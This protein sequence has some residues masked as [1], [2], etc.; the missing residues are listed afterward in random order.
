MKVIFTIDV[1][2]PFFHGMQRIIGRSVTGQDWGLERIMSTISQHDMLGICFV[3][4]YERYFHGDSAMR[5]V[6]HMI[7]GY[8]WEVGLHTHPGVCTHYGAGRMAGRP[9]SQ[10]IQILQDGES[11]LSDVLGSPILSHRAGGYGADDATIRALIETGIKADYSLYQRS[12]HCYI[13]AGPRGANS[14]FYIGTLLE[15]PV[16]STEVRVG[17]LHF[18]TKFDIAQPEELILRQLMFLQNQKFDYAVFFL[19]SFSLIDE[20][21]S[22]VRPVPSRL[23]KLEHILAAMQAAKISSCTTADLLQDDR[24]TESPAMRTILPLSLSGMVAYRILSAK[25]MLRARSAMVPIQMRRTLRR[26]DF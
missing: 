17:S 4:V 3:D 20:T 25:V 16:T 1:E 21:T 13:S 2:D 6:V 14:P 12:P 24:I 18:V 8:R 7:S 22:F 10:Q 26:C 5:D 11:W 23:L 9:S 19:H 15:V